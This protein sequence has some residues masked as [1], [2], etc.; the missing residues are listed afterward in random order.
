MK[1]LRQQCSTLW[2]FR[3]VGHR[4]S[5]AGT[6]KCYNWY[7]IYMHSIK[8]LQLSVMVVGYRYPPESYAAIKQRGQR[9]L[10]MILPTLVAS[11]LMNR[12]SAKTIWSG[13]AW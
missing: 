2:L 6:R 4:I 8:L 13:D 11:G 12:P 10:R 1:L 3:V 9:A 5:C 7:V